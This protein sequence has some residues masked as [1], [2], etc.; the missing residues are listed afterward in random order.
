MVIHRRLMMDVQLRDGNST[1]LV[2]AHPNVHVMMRRH[3]VDQ[4]MALKI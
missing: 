3:P 4:G 2:P 1:T